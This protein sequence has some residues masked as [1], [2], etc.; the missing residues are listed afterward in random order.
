MPRT[1][2][3]KNH[4][5]DPNKELEK[6]KQLFAEKGLDFPG[7]PPMYKKED[8]EDPEDPGGGLQIDTGD[9]TE[10]EDDGFECGACGEDLPSKLPN[11]PHCGANLTWS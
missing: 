5:P 10:T 3:A 4:P 9:K 2:G 11:C 8:P 1:Q 6:V 7:E